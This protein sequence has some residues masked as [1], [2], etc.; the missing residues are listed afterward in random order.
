MEG[1][2]K[3]G[4]EFEAD[5]QCAVRIVARHFLEDSTHAVGHDSSTGEKENTP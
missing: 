4:M 1:E 5:K 3:A 2:W